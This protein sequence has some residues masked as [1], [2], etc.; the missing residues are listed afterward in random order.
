MKNINFT[1]IEKIHLLDIY[2]GFEPVILKEKLSECH[3]LLLKARIM[4]MRLD[5]NGEPLNE[6]LANDIDKFLE[7]F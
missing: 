4:C 2:C 1:E 5:N 3:M 7:N 6:N